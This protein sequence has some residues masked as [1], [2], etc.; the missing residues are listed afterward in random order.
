VVSPVRLPAAA[1]TVVISG[2]GEFAALA[3]AAGTV[4]GPA[5]G[6]SGPVGLDWAGAAAVADAV[7]LTRQGLIRLSGWGQPFYWW[8]VE[9]VVVLNPQA[10]GGAA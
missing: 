6:G 7:W 4:P 9:T 8:D 3:A 2:Q 1:R 5:A 10:L